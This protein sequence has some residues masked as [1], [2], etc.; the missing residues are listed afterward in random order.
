M[1]LKRIASIVFIRLQ[2]GLDCV[3][4]IFLCCAFQVRRK[5]G[6]RCVGSVEAKRVLP[7]VLLL[8]A[9]MQELAVPI[10]KL[11]IIITN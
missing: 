11:Y 3:F 9:Y 8:Y 6:Q 1:Q 10:S 7:I 2:V 5:S 4:L